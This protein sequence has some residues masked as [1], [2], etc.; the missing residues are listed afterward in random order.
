MIYKTLPELN[1]HKKIMMQ[2]AG[3]RSASSSLNYKARSTEQ[4]IA[5]DCRRDKAEMQTSLA[6]KHPRKPV[7][8]SNLQQR[9]YDI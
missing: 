4:L 5:S 8:E 6:N 2:D 7:W 9:K 3:Q 1:S